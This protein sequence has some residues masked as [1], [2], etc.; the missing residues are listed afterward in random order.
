MKQLIINGIAKWIRS[1]SGDI[2]VYDFNPEQDLIKP[3]TIIE[4]VYSYI[5]VRIRHRERRVADDLALYQIKVIGKNERETRSILDRLRLSLDLIDCE[6]FTIRPYGIT[7]RM[8]YNNNANLQQVGYLQFYV[9]TKFKLK[10]PE[11]PTMNK[12]KFNVKAEEN[13]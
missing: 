13:G 6:E 10:A 9:R 5:D 11:V 1:V 8:T 7:S 12:L 3:C 2:H 4:E